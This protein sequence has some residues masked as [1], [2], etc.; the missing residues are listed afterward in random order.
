[1]VKGLDDGK[2]YEEQS[3]SLDFFS[4]EK[5][6]YSFFMRGNRGAGISLW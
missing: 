2:T 5:M 1:M 6:R 3:M 4:L